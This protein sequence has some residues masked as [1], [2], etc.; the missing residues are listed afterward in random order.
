[1]RTTILSLFFAASASISA[2]AQSAGTASLPQIETVG[3]GERRVAPDRAI[4]HLIVSTKAAAAANAAASNARAIQAV[5]DTLKRLGFDSVVTTASYNVGPDYES[6][7][8]RDDPKPRGYAARTIVRVRVVRLDQVGRIIDAALATGATG[9]QTV[10]FESSV[11]EDARRAAFSEASVGAKRDALA[12]AAALGGS[13]GSLISASAAGNTDPRLMNA[14]MG[15]AGGRAGGGAEIRPD[16]IVI[17]AVV[18]TRWEFIG[19]PAR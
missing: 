9:V 1:M 5:R 12:L 3:T 16:E 15:V 17:V 11:A 8:S 6:I 13:I 18:V 4:V 14:M 19:K 10:Q 2:S 7:V